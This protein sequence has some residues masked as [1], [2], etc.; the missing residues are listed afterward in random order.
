M[1]LEVTKINSDM[2]S[3]P[4]QELVQRILDRV[5]SVPWFERVGKPVTKRDVTCIENYLVDLGIP[6]VVGR[7][8]AN[9]QEV[10]DCLRSEFDSE[11]KH[12]DEGYVIV[13]HGLLDE[14]NRR[15]DFNTAFNDVSERVSDRVMSCA[16]REFGSIDEFLPRVA[17]GSAAEA[18]HQYALEEFSGR[19]MMRFYTRKLALFERGRWPLCGLGEEFLVY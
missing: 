17:A 1:N 5:D 13:L 14:S 6:D 7:V 18:C 4:D 8:V 16:E 12:V 9:V 11:W 19:K 3:L 10:Q 15:D 2:D